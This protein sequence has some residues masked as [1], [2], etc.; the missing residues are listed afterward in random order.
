M[1]CCKRDSFVFVTEFDENRQRR[2]FS[3]EHSLCMCAYEWI[4]HSTGVHTARI[5]AFWPA[6]SSVGVERPTLCCCFCCW[7]RI[8]FC[9]FV[10]S[11]PYYSVSFVG[12]VVARI[13]HGYFCLDTKRYELVGCM[14]RARRT[15]CRIADSTDAVCFGA[16]ARQRSYRCLVQ[17]TANKREIL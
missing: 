5:Y 2:R 6:H 17:K 12:V 3:T 11:R 16:V 7:L 8:R 10:S 9:V 13:Q 1:W 4:V 15:V 14:L